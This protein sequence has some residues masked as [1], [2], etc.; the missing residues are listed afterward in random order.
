MLRAQ[1]DQI[2][3]LASDRPDQAFNI[4]PFCQGEW[5]DVGRSRPAPRNF[6]H[7]KIPA[8]KVERGERKRTADEVKADWMMSKP[9]ADPTSGMSLGDTLRLP[10]RLYGT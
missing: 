9:G 6:L 1:H 8:G 5:N 3:A 10:K 7:L 4:Y 2:S